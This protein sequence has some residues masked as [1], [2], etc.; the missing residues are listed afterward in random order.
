MLLC[1]LDFETTGLDSANDRVTEVGAVLYSTTR[2]RQ[3]MTK[4]YFVDNETPISKE[5]TDITGISTSMIDKFGL[6]SRSALDDLL[7]MIDMSEAVIG[8]N[9]LDFD[10]PFLKNWCIREKQDLPD[11]LIIDT[12]MDL[13]GVV[14]KHLGYMCADAG[15]LNPFPH[16]A[17]SDALSVIRLVADHDI[18]AVIARAKS[19]RVSLVADVDFDHNHL[20]KQRK[21]AWNPDRKVWFKNLKEMDVDDEVKNAPFNVMKVDWIPFH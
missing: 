16:C 9:I 18:E 20:A 3:L 19:P 13:P 10:W 21:Y 5:I 2:D 17:I 8:Q 15:F 6:S 12:R 11:R 7:N 4:G 1:S 14:S